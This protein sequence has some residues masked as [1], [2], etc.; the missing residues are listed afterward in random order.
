MSYG[1]KLSSFYYSTR[2]FRACGLVCM[3]VNIMHAGKVLLIKDYPVKQ[4]IECDN[5]EWLFWAEKQKI[6]L[7]GGDVEGERTHYPN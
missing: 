6:V 4:K 2:K 3:Y 5:W 1:V 7:L